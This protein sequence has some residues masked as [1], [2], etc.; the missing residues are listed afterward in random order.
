MPSQ[1]HEYIASRGP[2]SA[3][4]MQQQKRRPSAASEDIRQNQTS[5]NVQYKRP[6]MHRTMSDEE[7]V[8]QPNEN[9]IA[10]LDLPSESMSESAAAAVIQQKWRCARLRRAIAAWEYAGVSVDRLSELGFDKAAELMK[11]SQVVESSERLMD[12]L[13]QSPGAHETDSGNVKCKVPG[14][15]LVTGFLFAAHS[16]LLVT[17]TSHM[18]TMVEAAAVAMTK[19]YVE[20]VSSFTSHDNSWYERQQTFVISFKAFDAAFDSW[21]RSDSQRL[22]ATMERHYL[23][24]DRLWQTVQRR[25]GGEGDEEWR[26]GIQAQ[27]SDLMKKIHML[28]GEDAVKG[29]IQKQNELRSTYQDPQPSR[30]PSLES[31]SATMEREESVVEDSKT[32]TISG[33]RGQRVD[34]AQSD[35]ADAPKEAKGMFDKDHNLDMP[36]T[37]LTKATL[38]PSSQ[39]VDR[40]LGSYN[41]TATAALENAKIA[42]EL[43]LDP[44][45]RLKVDQAS[46]QHDAEKERLVESY[47]ADIK[48]ET[49]T[50][51]Q[52]RL[53][54]VFKQLR[55]ELYTVIPPGS[56]GR[57][58]LDRELDADW[59]QSKLAN[60]ALDIPS[61][62]LMIIQLL[63]NSCAAIR[64]ETIESLCARARAFKDGTV[65]ISNDK[66]ISEFVD[67]VRGIFSLIHNMRIDVLN[68]RLD[69]VVRPWLRIHA[70]EYERSKLAQL[71]EAKCNDTEQMLEETTQWMYSAAARMRQE[72]QQPETED[73]SDFGSLAKSIF[74]EALLD[75]CFAAKALSSKDMPVTL[76]LDQKRIWKIQN[77]VQVITCT[78]ALCTLIRGALHRSGTQI[79]VAEQQ[80]IA[81]ALARC[82]RAE[83]VTIDKVITTVRNTNSNSGTMS[84]ETLERLVRKTLDKSDPIYKATEQVLRKFIASEIDK[85]ETA[86]ALAQRLRD[87]QQQIK[88]ELARI[89][90]NAIDE[91]VN[92]LVERIGRLCEFNWKVHSPW[93]RKI[94]Y[95]PQ[96]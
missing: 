12:V 69:T 42:H 96:T 58:S 79:S 20:F 34:S 74:R 47:L 43:I 14:R 30:T 16:Q 23:E 40:I 24:L 80:S 87:S 13:L 45:T 32:L 55:V 4:T 18:D 76:A 66:G 57:E 5:G 56:T 86:D 37:L 94:C 84:A 15:V 39:D 73:I 3:P 90:L 33:V 38:D 75:I 89:S 17:G 70:V 59:M 26:I 46:E 68:Y 64:D 31:S 7:Q 29:V 95:K 9:N 81:R 44:E 72:Q 53:L 28:G 51:N 49:E 52:S 21:K 77:E 35:I 60:G 27:R 88:A 1:E 54:H 10:N 48:R 82:L 85:N 83:D 63:G 6:Y 67:L 92:R 22:L 78:G 91:D 8:S 93:Y 65:E 2:R 36:M 41:L 25:T 50:G 62:L 11:S 19:S 61:T 71:L